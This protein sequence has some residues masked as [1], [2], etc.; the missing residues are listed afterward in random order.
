ML[1]DF[2][3]SLCKVKGFRGY[4]V[5]DSLADSDESLILTFWATQADMDQFYQPNNEA[6]ASFVEKGKGIMVKPPQ[7]ADY[8]IKG[9]KMK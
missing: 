6:L 8:V 7:R 2:F 3:G 4:I 9:Y 5:L 1:L